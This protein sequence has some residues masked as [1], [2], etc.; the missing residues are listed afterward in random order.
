[1]LYYT[2]FKTKIKFFESLDENSRNAV[3]S[4]LNNTYGH[5]HVMTNLFKYAVNQPAN[6]VI[7][8]ITDILRLRKVGRINVP[9]L[10]TKMNWT[11]R[12]RDY[13]GLMKNEAK[14]VKLATKSNRS[15]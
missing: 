1:M 8:S 9:G 7:I 14:L 15:A 13:V 3:I 10:K 12:L 6:T 2:H 4:Y 5:H 11:F